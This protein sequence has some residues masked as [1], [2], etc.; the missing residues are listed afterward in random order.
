MSKCLLALI[1]IGILTSPQEWIADGVNSIKFKEL[2]I[3]SRAF[4]IIEISSIGTEKQHVE[5]LM[6]KDDY[7]HI[8]TST[9]LIL[10]SEVFHLLSRIVHKLERHYT[11]TFASVS[12]HEN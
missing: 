3:I 12:L 1:E 10:F 9:L 4:R 2:K 6:N 11:S 8:S 5:E 7:I